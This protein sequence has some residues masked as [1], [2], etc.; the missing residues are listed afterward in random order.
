[1]VA[2]STAKIN[3]IIIA[4]SFCACKRGFLSLLLHGNEKAPKRR[5]SLLNGILLVYANGREEGGG[6]EG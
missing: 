2:V 6:G 1:M 3:F 5:N 4:F